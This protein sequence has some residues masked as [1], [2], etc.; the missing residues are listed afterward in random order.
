LTAD[1]ISQNL[2]I[3]IFTVNRNLDSAEGNDMEYKKVL[4]LILDGFGINESSYGNA[5]KA[6]NMPVYRQFRKD[7]PHN[8]LIASGTPVGL[9]PGIMGNSEVGHLNIGAGRIIYQQNLKID[10]MIKDGSF[11]QNAALLHG[12]D[13][14][15]ENDSNLHLLGLLSD[16][17]VHST[18]EHLWPILKMAKKKG[19]TKVFIHAFMDGRDTLTHSGRNFLINTEEK[20][21]EIGIGKIATVSGRFYAMDR[22][23]NIHRTH[24]AYDALVYGKGNI[25]TSVLEVINSSYDNDVTDEFVKPAV[26]TENGKPVAQISNN[27]SVIFFNY[28]A[29][30]A[31]QLTRSFILPDDNNFK[32]FNNLKFVSFREYDIDFNEYVE[33]AFPPEKYPDTL[34]ETIS[35]HGLKQLHLAETE[36]YSHVTFFFNGGLEKSYPGEDRILVP[37]PKVETYDLQPEMSAFQ[38]KNELVN[39]ITKSEHNL[40]IT[41]FA[42][43][44]MVG[45]TGDF[46]AAVK[47]IEAVDN[48]LAEI[49]PAARKHDYNVILIADHGNADQMLNDNGEILT[50]HSTNPVPVIVSLTDKQNYLVSKGKLADVAPTILKIM[51][52]PI[53]EE[54]TGSVLI[55]D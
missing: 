37:S 39:A 5:I 40:I 17:N 9:P 20:L 15:L 19:L 27:D 42:N 11:Y 30:R 51:G 29:D 53:P 44:D 35:N 38:V 33:V 32:K 8:Q 46:A 25:H 48:C 31:R 52:I 43:P 28:R 24:E 23:N 6:A 4:L 45:H 3:R 10:N 1:T 22:D 12:I 34:A 7:N 2:L 26:I 16:G 54:M 50:Q 41:N 49:L 36:K 55:S 47:A 21:Q 14:A 18:M 13:H